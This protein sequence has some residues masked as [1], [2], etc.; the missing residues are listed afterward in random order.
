MALFMLL[1]RATDLFS[2]TIIA[3]LCCILTQSQ[4]IYQASFRFCSWAKLTVDEGS[5]IS[6]QLNSCHI[7]RSSRPG[8]VCLWSVCDITM[9]WQSEG[10][11]ALS[12]GDLYPIQSYCCHFHHDPCIDNTGGAHTLIRGLT[13]TWAED[14]VLKGTYTQIQRKNAHMHRLTSDP[15]DCW[16]ETCTYMHPITLVDAGPKMTSCRLAY[17]AMV[18]LDWPW[19]QW[20]TIQWDS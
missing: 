14:W 1:H 12:T 5:I 19:T 6:H 16:C 20:C 2:K 18:R 4:T 17:M 15:F 7:R 3:L 11:C 8:L 10:A 13:H 9:W